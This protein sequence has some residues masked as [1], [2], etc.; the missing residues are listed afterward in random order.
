MTPRNS[1]RSTSCW[2]TICWP[3]TAILASCEGRPTPTP[4]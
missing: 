3:S 2:P 1:T 4:N